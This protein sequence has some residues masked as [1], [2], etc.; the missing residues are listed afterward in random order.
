ME[1][2]KINIYFLTIFCDSPPTSW[3]GE[4]RDQIPEMNFV[5]FFL[6]QL[7]QK[8]VFTSLNKKR[9]IK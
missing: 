1:L 5:F 9:K 6:L 4:L 2:K 3:L 7:L 8:Y